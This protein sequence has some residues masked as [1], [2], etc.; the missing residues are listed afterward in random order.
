M[1]AEGDYVRLEVT[2]SGCGMTEQV[3]ARIFDP[4][5]TSKFA[6]RGLGLASVQGIVRGHGGAIRL[7]SAPGQGSRFEIFLPCSEARERAGAA[8]SVSAVEGAAPAATV[9][10]VE[11]E[12][13]LRT[14]VSKILRMRGFA[15]IEAADGRIA[16]DLFRKSSRHVDVV[17]LDLNLPGISGAE[18]LREL[19][20]IRPGAKVILTSAYSREWAHTNVGGHHSWPYIRKPYQ[21]GELT[22]LLRD[23]CLGKERVEG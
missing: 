7:V 19:Q 11:D 23:I 17:L 8:P 12:E 13:P 6:G 2:D 14:A 5:F 10:L 1:L 9:L 15:V 20:R 3:Q 4:F 21:V 22:A 18:V 16:V